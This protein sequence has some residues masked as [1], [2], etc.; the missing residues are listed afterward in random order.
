MSALA[1]LDFDEPELGGVVLFDE[2]VGGVVVLGRYRL[3]LFVVGVGVDVGVG[4][5]DV[6]VFGVVDVVV[7]GVVVSP[8][9]ATLSPIT[10]RT[11][12]VCARVSAALDRNSPAPRPG[13]HS[14]SVFR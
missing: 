7:F 9:A 11:A 6:V 4:V 14:S 10:L 5:V 8:A 2:L 12:S 1:T 13:A 3:F